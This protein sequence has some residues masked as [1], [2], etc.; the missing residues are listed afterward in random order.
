MSRDPAL[1]AE[2]FERYRRHIVLP[3]MGLEGQ[4]RLLASSVLLIGAGG[5]VVRWPST[6]R[7]PG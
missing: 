6:S 7:Q 3:E 4:K 1:S 2:Q 5:W